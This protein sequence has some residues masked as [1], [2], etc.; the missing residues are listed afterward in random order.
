MGTSRRGLARD[1]ISGVIGSGL[2]IYFAGFSVHEFP[3]QSVTTL[4]FLLLEALYIGLL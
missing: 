2:E 1:S 4:G 3:C